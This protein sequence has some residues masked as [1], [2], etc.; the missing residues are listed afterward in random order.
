[1]IDAAVNGGIVEKSGSWFSY[2][3]DRLGQGRENAKQFI[4]ENQ[5]VY[6]EIETKV[7]AALGMM[8]DEEVSSP[9]DQS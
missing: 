3:S 4:A 2:G 1:M 5:A 7:K 6:Q 8:S 9:K